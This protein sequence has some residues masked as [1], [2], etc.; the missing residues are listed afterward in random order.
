MIDRIQQISKKNAQYVPQEVKEENAF[1]EASE[2]QF[3]ELGQLYNDFKY[4][5]IRKRF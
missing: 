5:N 3:E 4:R 2:E 1:T